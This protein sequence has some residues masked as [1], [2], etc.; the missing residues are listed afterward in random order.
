MLARH[1]FPRVAGAASDT[2]ADRSGLSARIVQDCAILC[3]ENA[4]KMIALVEE[5]RAGGSS[6]HCATGDG[7]VVGTIP[8]WYRVLYLHVPV[9]VL[10]AATLQPQLCTPAVAESWGRAMAALR[11]HEHLT[12][13]VSQCLAALEVLSS[14]IG[15]AGAQ[16]QLQLQQ[17]TAAVQPP[18]TLGAGSTSINHPSAIPLQDLLFQDVVFDS[19][20]ALLFGMEDMS[21]MSNLG[22]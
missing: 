9:T 1:C 13:F 17:T 18:G 21:W 11:A 4:Q 20:D 2:T 10:M 19:A 14:R 6:D 5:C 12:P 16:T 22:T 8:W 15:G 3:V 7:D